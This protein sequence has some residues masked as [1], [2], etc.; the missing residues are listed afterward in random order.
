M[1]ADRVEV[2]E[3]WMALIRSSRIVCH[4]SISSESERPSISV[5]FQM[6]T[7]VS[8]ILAGHKVTGVCVN[9][10]RD[11]TLE[12]RTRWQEVSGLPIKLQDVGVVSCLSWSANK[13]H[14]CTVQCYMPFL[15]YFPT[16]VIQS[17]TF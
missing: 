10:Y 5:S 15:V 1:A 6:I 13:P 11:S 8:R 7:A 12:N 16:P 17:R 3:L 2:K 9:L 14:I 4:I